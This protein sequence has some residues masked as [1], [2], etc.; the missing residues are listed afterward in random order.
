[1]IIRNQAVFLIIEEA[2]RLIGLGCNIVRRRA[3]ECHATRK[4]GRILRINRDVPLKKLYISH[5]EALVCQAHDKKYIYAKAET[6]NYQLYL[7]VWGFC[8]NL[9]PVF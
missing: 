7:I 3:A 4:I 9:N 5:I 1:M 8:F 6:P 2:V